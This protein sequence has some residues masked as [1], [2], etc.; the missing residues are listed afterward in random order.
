M[1]NIILIFKEIIFN[2]QLMW[3]VARYNNKAAFQGHYFGLAWEILDPLIQIGIYFFMF[4][5]MRAR[6][7][8]TVGMD[9]NTIDVP[10]FAWMLIGMTAWL[11]MNKVIL[12]GAQS[13]QKKITLVSKMQFPMSIIPGMTLASRLTSYF[14]T[15]I[16]MVLVLFLMGFFPTLYWIQFIYYFIAMLIFVYFFTL[17]NSTLT[18]LFRDYINILRPFMRFMMF[19][20]GVIWNIAEMPR[21]PN[22]F[23]R[24]MDLNPFSYITTGFRYTFFSRAYFWQHPE[25]SIFFWL[26]VLVIALGASHLHLKYRNKFIDLA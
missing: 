17:L 18:M 12:S 19:F 21:M 13:I 4:G 11:F 1:K 6:P 24:L 2:L 16:T 14:V 25:T 23:V 15:V 3:T 26:L 7:D 20:A 22:W 8:I 9:G 10:F 5:L